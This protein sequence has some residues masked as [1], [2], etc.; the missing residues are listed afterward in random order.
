MKRKLMLAG[1][2]SI[3]LIATGCA[4]GR[5]DAPTDENTE[6]T[7]VSK[8]PVEVETLQK[9]MIKEEFYSLGTVEAGRTYNMNALVNADVKKRY[10]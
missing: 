4:G 10:T 3:A 6:K 8:I 1:I 7:E 9:T 5:P 2:L